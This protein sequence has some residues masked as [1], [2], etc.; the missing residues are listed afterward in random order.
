MN[1]ILLSALVG[2]ITKHFSVAKITIG[3]EGHGRES[4][5]DQLDISGTVGWFT[6][7]YPLVLNAS[8]VNSIEDLIKSTKEQVREVPEKGIGYGILRYMSDDATLRKALANV[9]WDIEFNYLGQLDNALNSNDWLS[10]ATENPGENLHKNTPHKTRLDVN[11]F[12]ADGE[13][14]ISF[15]YSSKD[16]DEATIE[17]IANA[18]IATLTAIIEHCV[19]QNKI[20]KTPS[21]YELQGKVSY[22]ELDAFFEKA[23]NSTNEISSIY[24][25]SPMQEGMLFHGLYDDSSISYTNQIIMG[26]PEGLDIETFKKSKIIELSD[27]QI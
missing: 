20:T 26:F 14:Q 3:V 4:L 12:I 21:D 18:Y 2:S 9:T 16:Y 13:L 27:T 6:N 24:E 17:T 23:G 19:S 15:G 1:D 8:E 22:Q 10:A 11:S 25:L 7:V 5:F